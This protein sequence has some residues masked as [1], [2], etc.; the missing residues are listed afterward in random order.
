MNISESIQRQG[1]R[2]LQLGVL[3]FLAALLVGLGVPTFAVPRLALSVHLLG[4]LQGI[5]LM[6]L[7]TVWPRLLV[8]T[9]M[10]RI[11]FFLLVYGCIA[12][13]TANLLAAIWGAGNAMLPIAAGAAHGTSIQE[14]VI[15]V[16]LRSAAVS[17]IA[18]AVLVLWGLRAVPGAKWGR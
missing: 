13:W 11:G 7:G 12:A 17:L 18:A 14:G 15:A 9:A 16:A 10:A 8:T 4:L 3:L 5:F 1:H 6:V 2:L